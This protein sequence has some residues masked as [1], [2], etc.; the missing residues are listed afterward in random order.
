M[1]GK[2]KKVILAIMDGWGINRNP[3]NSA[4]EA[5]K[6]PFIDS[7][8]L[9]Y[10]N[11]GLLTHGE[12]VGLPADQMGNSEVGHMNLGAGRV[13]YQDLLLINKKRETGELKQNQTLLEAFNYA[14]TNN[15]KVHFLGLVSDGG[16][17]AHTSHLKEL[18]KTACF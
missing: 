6:T 18:I 4:I 3:A 7:L 2:Q 8:Y 11:T 14:K 9:K 15:K 13:I 1:K 16:I 5:A 17:H 12:Y 10:K